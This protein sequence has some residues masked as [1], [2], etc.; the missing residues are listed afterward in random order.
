MAAFHAD[1]DALA[2]FSSDVGSLWCRSIDVLD[3]PPD[4]FTFLRDYV[5]PKVPCII[6]NA[7]PRETS[8]SDGFLSLTLDDIIRR[9]GEDVQITVDVTP[10][11]HGDAVRTVERCNSSQNIEMQKM[12]I[13]PHEQEM[14]LAE[15]RSLLISKQTDSINSGSSGNRDAESTDAARINACTT[16][17]DH[18]N[19]VYPTTEA[20]LQQNKRHN[21]RV[22]NPVV[23]Y[24]RQNDCLRTEMHSLF[25]TGL[26]P[27]SFTF[28]EE[29]FDTGPPDAIN[30]WVGNE[31]SVSSMHKDHYENLFYVC[32][33]VCNAPADIPFMHEGEFE[34]GAFYPCNGE[35]DGLANASWTI[36]PDSNSKA[37]KARWIEPDIKR[38]LDGGYSQKEFPLLSKS[39]PIK[40]FVSKG[41]MLYIPSLWLHR[42]TQTTETVGINYWYD[43]KFDSAHWCY[44]NFLQQL[45]RTEESNGTNT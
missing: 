13:R 34:T 24:S 35:S 10:D 41:E 5:S 11:G 12:F 19:S 31:R 18:G 25:S 14:T 39:H 7:I 29:A 6:R 44:F 8:S 4:S 21:A 16:L 43:M 36:V 26:I 42:V 15:F 1:E 28:A 23:Y 22:Q 40:V 20:A 33:G 30:L 9:V 38:Y 2:N 37:S 17:D 32:S 45:K 3:R 27:K